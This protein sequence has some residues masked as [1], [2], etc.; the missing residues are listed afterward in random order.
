MNMLV[1]KCNGLEGSV[2]ISGAKNAALPILAAALLPDG[3]SQICQVPMLRDITAM[4]HLLDYMGCSCQV[5]GDSILIDPK[6]VHRCEAPYELVST[7]RGSFLVT[8]PLVA[9]YGKAKISLPGGCPI[10]TRPVDLHLKGL[11]AM[12]AQIEYGSGYVEISSDRLFGTKLYLDFPSVG[13]TENLIMAACLAEGVTLIENA[14]TEPEIV[15]L[16]NFLNAMGA[17]ITGAGS[18]TV[19]ITGVTSLHAATHTIIP[20]RIEA[21]TFMCAAAATMGDIMVKNVI[22]KHLEATTAKLE[23]IG[24]QVEEFDDAV[25]VVANK[26]LK[27]T[28]VKTM[29]Y[30][31]YPTDMQPQFAVALTLAEGTSIITESIFENRFKYAAELVRMGA[32]IKVEGNTAIVNGVEKLTGAQVSAPDLRAGAALVIAGLAAEGIT[33]VDDIVYIQRGYERFEEKLRSLGAEIEKVSSE[34]E[35]KKFQLRVG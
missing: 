12:G 19:K 27:R 17:C 16:A 18:D 2:R 9:K 26:R 4:L 21:G 13:A 22:P 7:F 8:G 6:G 3:E 33:I 1:K 30:P 5:Q 11:A 14:A 29:P 25:R 31:G 35:I 24:C 28:N 34:K 23:E 10:G 15:D 32:D 20:D